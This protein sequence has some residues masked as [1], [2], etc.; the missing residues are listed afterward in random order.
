MEAIG[1]IVGLVV[2]IV[3]IL[4]IRWIGAWMLRIDE[5]ITELKRINKSINNNKL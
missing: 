4:L 2:F 1:I 5:V 3:F